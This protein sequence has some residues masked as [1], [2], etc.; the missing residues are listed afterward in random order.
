MMLVLAFNTTGTYVHWEPSLRW[1]GIVGSLL[2][3][4]G[5]RRGWGHNMLHLS[6]TGK[7]REVARTRPYHWA[8][9]GIMWKGS[10][11]SAIYSLASDL[12]NKRQSSVFPQDATAYNSLNI[13]S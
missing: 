10:V 5:Y 11:A 8:C 12:E 7:S 3:K 9:L 2:C 1:V 6:R 4:R 13:L